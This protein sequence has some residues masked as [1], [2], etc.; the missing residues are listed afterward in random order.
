ML[1]ASFWFLANSAATPMGL[2]VPRSTCRA[3]RFAGRCVALFVATRPAVPLHAA[4]EAI[5]RK[6]ACRLRTRSSASC[7]RYSSKNIIIIIIIIIIQESRQGPQQQQQR[8]HCHR[9][10]PPAPAPRAP[11][12]MVGPTTSRKNRIW[13]WNPAHVRGQLKAMYL[14]LHPFTVQSMCTP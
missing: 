9:H 5:N 12:I 8:R 6:P 4:M 7:T 3:L 1:K 2:L 11:R 14:R 10:R 13:K